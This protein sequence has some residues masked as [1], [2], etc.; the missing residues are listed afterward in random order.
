MYKFVYLGGDG[1]NV[2]FSVQTLLKQS[3][4]YAMCHVH[5]LEFQL[6]Q[7]KFHYY[8]YNN[9]IPPTLCYLGRPLTK[10]VGFLISCSKTSRLDFC[11]VYSSSL[12]K[13]SY[14]MYLKLIMKINF[15]ILAYFQE[16]DKRI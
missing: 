2:K 5:K 16:L 1:T 9:N 3:I 4:L 14:V 12:A 10:I 7:I 6:I 11:T 15:N 13:F 8:T